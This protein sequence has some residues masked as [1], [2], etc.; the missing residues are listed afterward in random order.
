MCVGGGTTCV[1]GVNFR[2]E[3]ELEGRSWWSQVGVG[4]SDRGLA[5][6]PMVWARLWWDRWC[7]EQGATT[8]GWRR[9]GQ[10]EQPFSRASAYRATLTHS[11]WQ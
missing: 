10:W 2:W 3:H 1:G 4:W 6:V 9:L 11:G 5:L 8:C 7:R